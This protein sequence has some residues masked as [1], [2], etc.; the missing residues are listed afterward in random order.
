MR[1]PHQPGCNLCRNYMV[2]AQG[3][4]DHRRGRELCKR[5]YRRS[6][7]RHT[8]NQRNALAQSQRQYLF[9]RCSYTYRQSLYSE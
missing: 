1:E 2:P 7:K 9:R 3:P 5:V 8:Y 6:G 4:G